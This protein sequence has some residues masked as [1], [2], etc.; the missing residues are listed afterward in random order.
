MWLV[1]HFRLLRSYPDFYPL[2]DL[3]RAHR[4]GEYWEVF[5]ES[6]ETLEVVLS[7]WHFYWHLSHLGIELEF[8][9]T[10]GQCI[11]SFSSFTHRTFYCPQLLLRQYGHDQG[12]PRPRGKFYAVARL[13][14]AMVQA[15]VRSWTRRREPPSLPL[16]SDPVALEDYPEWR[17]HFSSYSQIARDDDE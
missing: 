17:S 3:I 8:F 14:G 9:L 11:L 2:S 16:S 7:N 15:L 6:Q 4:D 1:E 10:R 5:S 13:N 12:I